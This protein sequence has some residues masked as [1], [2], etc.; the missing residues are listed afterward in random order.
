MLEISL[1]AQ[2]NK[3]KSGFQE[4]FQHIFRI[5]KKNGLKYTPSNFLSTIVYPRLAL[6]A[7]FQIHHKLKLK[8]Q[9]LITHSPRGEIRQTH[10]SANLALLT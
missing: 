9:K 1:F 3:K 10:F 5:F 4:N 7:M 2:S 6:L 8:Y